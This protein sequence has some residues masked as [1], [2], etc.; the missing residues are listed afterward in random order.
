MIKLPDAPADVIAHP[1][2]FR[3]QLPLD[4][5]YRYTLLTEAH[6]ESVIDVFVRAFCR[7]EPMTKYLHMDE[8]KF[9]VF[10]RAVTEKACRDQLSIVCLD[11]T[12]VVACALVED[13]FQP[14]EIPEFDPTFV[15]IMS[16]LD[17]LGSTYFADKIFATGQIAHLLI[18]A[19]ADDYRRQGL[20]IQVNF[21]AM[22][23]AA[24]RGFGF[25]YSELTNAFNQKGIIH[26]LKSP[27]RCIGQIV[28]RDYRYQ[29]ECPFSQLDGAAASYLWA[30]K[31]NAKLVY[32]EK[33]TLKEEILSDVT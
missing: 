12:K 11:G 27:K 2:F 19:V 20:S 9:Q 33:N 24:A 6:I 31:E 26:H 1:N 17:S 22:D 14:G 7:S 23:L 18:T 21:R 28:Y 30:I 32:R 3:N 8:K 13:L 29:N 5:R 4:H 16:L 15:Y 10:A 25:M